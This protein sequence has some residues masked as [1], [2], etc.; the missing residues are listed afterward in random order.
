MR[1]ALSHIVALLLPLA[2]AACQP[3]PQP[4]QHGDLADNPL[5][6]LKDGPGV[7]LRPIEGLDLHISDE[8]TS[9]VV[10]AFA[11]QDVPASAVIGNRASFRL[12]GKGA[13]ASQL[14]GSNELVVDWQLADAGG[15]TLAERRQ[16]ATIEAGPAR[17]R[18]FAR[19]AELLVGDLM[20]QLA[21]P[22]LKAALPEAV[23]VF[24]VDGAPGDG[25]ISLKQALEYVLMKNGVPLAQP[26]E[27]NVLVVSAQITMG[28]PEAGAQ[29][30]AIR[31]SLHGPDGKEI[32]TVTQAN[33]VPAGSLDHA[34]G[35]TA[36]A[37]AEAAY[38]GLGALFQRVWSPP[39]KTPGGKG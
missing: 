12:T 28:K 38:D 5:V 30:I 21:E 10:D 23:L 14:G 9:A 11:A 37:V 25:G 39:L 35:D 20:P 27:D 4:F 22:R 33:T 1:A 15:R 24:S 16:Q 36:L 29:A 7:S 8:I 31:W 13:M 34:W 2:L 18:S 6:R 3:L 19:M 32:G 26:R 17:R